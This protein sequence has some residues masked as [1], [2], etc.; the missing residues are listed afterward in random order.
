MLAIIFQFLNSTI[1]RLI[2]VA[3]VAGGSG[4]YKGGHDEKLEWEAKEAV[5]VKAEL[6]RA[7][8]QAT[9]DNEKALQYRQE[10]D[11]AAARNATLQEKYLAAKAKADHS[12]SCK[13]DPVVRKSIQ[14]II[15]EQNRRISQ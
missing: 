2:V 9:I 15:E 7:A 1:G 12:K 4:Y 8:K 5:A 6:A 13:S 3:V 10:A 14:D 11:E